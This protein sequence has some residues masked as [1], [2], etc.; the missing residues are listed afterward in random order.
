MAGKVVRG[1]AWT[2][3]EAAPGLATMVDLATPRFAAPS[4]IS[5]GE[6]R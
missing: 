6:S 4:S 3:R 1:R 5:A 2:S